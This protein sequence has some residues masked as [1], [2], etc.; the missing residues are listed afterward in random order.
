MKKDGSL[1]LV[2]DY[3][4]LNKV[5]IENKYAPPFISSLLE[6]INGAEYFTKIYLRGAYN[7]VQI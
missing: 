1:R 3:Q 2:V 6:H 4:G 7:L 5:T